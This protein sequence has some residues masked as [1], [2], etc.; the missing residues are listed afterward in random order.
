[1][2]IGG[3]VVAT[4]IVEADEEDTCHEDGVDVLGIGS[5]QLRCSG[6]QTLGIFEGLV[7]L[8]IRF[9]IQPKLGEA[10]FYHGK[11]VANVGTQGQG[12]VLDR[13][14]RM[15]ELENG[16]TP[17]ERVGRL[18]LQRESPVTKRVE[19]MA[20]IVVGKAIDDLQ[21]RGRKGTGSGACN[22]DGILRG[23]ISIRILL[24]RNR[25]WLS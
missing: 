1:M 5:S 24:T 15:T 11:V 18:I 4:L 10:S 21:D 3:G 19:Q 25:T 7:I 16:S 8:S 2:G 13:R 22:G 9:I 6:Q 23:R 17:E 14:L 20:F 12:D